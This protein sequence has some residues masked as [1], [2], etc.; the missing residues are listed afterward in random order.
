MILSGV[1]I[2]QAV[3]KGDL[4]I[5]PFDV[6]NLKGAS[7]TL[8]L[9][10][11]LSIP[12]KAGVLGLNISPEYEEVVMGEDGFILNPGDFVL[13]YTN[14]KLSLNGNYACLLS[15]RSS[16]AR[17]GLNVLLGSNFVE[18]DTDSLQILEIHNAAASPIRLEVGMKIV[19]GIFYMVSYNP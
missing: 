9:S 15:V 11:K 1:A 5:D 16:C 18:P 10:S 4:G 14:E 8:S 17:L 6:A 19:K 7:Y 12:K 2:E 3:K 13:G